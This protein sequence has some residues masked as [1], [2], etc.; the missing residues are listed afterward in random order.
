MKKQR[1][2]LLTTLIVSALHPNEPQAPGTKWEPTNVIDIQEA[3]A[4][5]A[6]NYAEKVDAAKDDTVT[7]TWLQR[8]DEA[9]RA[10]AAKA[11]VVEPTTVTIPEDDDTLSDEEL[12][13][14]LEGN[15]DQVAAELDGLTVEQL[16]RLDAMEASEDGKKR[17]GVAD[18]I[19]D[20]IAALEADPE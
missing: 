9:K 5:V 10:A 18:A 8:Q 17:K 11:D 6:S 20:A 3:D 19:A 14:V 4:L 7:P 1:Y 16:Q 13:L 15:V 12:A 2:N